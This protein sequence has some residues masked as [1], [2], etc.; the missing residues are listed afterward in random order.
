MLCCLPSILDKVAITVAEPPT[1]VLTTFVLRVTLTEGF[2]PIWA[3][4]GGIKQ[5]AA[6]LTAKTTR[7]ERRRYP[8]SWTIILAEA[9][10]KIPPRMEPMFQLVF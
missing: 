7:K 2:A 8:D 10:F 1:Y 6:R 9:F 4:A 3:R 5:P